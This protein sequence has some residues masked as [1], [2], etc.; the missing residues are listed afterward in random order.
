[1][2]GLLGWAAMA[3]PHGA[4]PRFY[5]DDPLAREPETQD[6][7]AVEAWDIDLFVDLTTNLFGHPGDPV[8][9]QRARNVNTADE[10]PDSSWFTNRIG[11]RTLSA[12][13]V[14]RGPVA[15]AGPAPGPWTVIRPKSSGFAP[16]FTMRDSA[17]ETWF[18]SFDPPGMPDAAT[19][20]IMVA[21]KLFWA[22]GYFQ[23]DT[24]LGRIA[25]D[26]IRI[27]D[28]AMMRLPTGRRRPMQRRDIDDVLRRSH[29]S[30]DGTYRAALGRML[31]GRVVGGFRYHG[32]R[33]D[34]PN[35]VV[36]HEH[37]R[38]L[39][40]LKVFGAWTNLVDMKAGNTLDTVITENGRGV[41]RHYLQDV[42]S[43]F[44]TGAQGPR[45]YDEGWE[46]LY[47]GK[48][49]LARLFTLGLAMPR[50]TT[51]D[52]TAN[53]SIGRFEGEAFDPTVW[54]PRVPTAAFRHAR[55]DDDFWAAR[56]VAAFSD[57][58]IA[59]AVASGE[60][61]DPA[62]AALLTRVLIERRDKIAQAFLPAVNPVVDVAM[63][64]DGVVSFA[65][66]A[67]EAGVAAPPAGYRVRW[68]RFDNATDTASPLGEAVQATDTRAAPPAALPATGGSFVRV[69]IAA[70]GG[71]P[72]WAAPVEAYFR[73]ANDRW[74]LVGF[75]RLPE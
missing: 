51:I 66:A 56:R 47:E 48:P 73:R 28:T 71:P 1:M 3:G 68:H 40:A 32:T 64:D 37:R 61:A 45:E 70:T 29:R 22:L 16:G 72:A 50:W 19:S 52:Y 55:A 13:A 62:A 12:E 20:A 49:L 60:Y 26:Q 39:R 53:R 27:A 21:T 14:A 17:G 11:A 30:A 67:V 7:S 24:H 35:D 6:A 10:V 15:G 4:A 18:V 9:N 46:Y 23:V 74:Q 63:A 75:N 44:G 34:D 65:N 59:A 38:E 2:T 33:P 69:D 31:P 41:V 5:A 57:A 25:P 54:R 36:P 42:G 8:T 43:T 58:L